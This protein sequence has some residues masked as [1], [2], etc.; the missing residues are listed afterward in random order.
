MKEV[1]VFYQDGMMGI[2]NARKLQGLIESDRIIKF[3]RSDGWVYPDI[4]PIRSFADSGYQG[5]ERRF[6]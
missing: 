2:V 6:V 1:S 3:Q 5:S 4:D